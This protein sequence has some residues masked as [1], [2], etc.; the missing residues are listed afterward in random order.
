MCGKFVDDFA[1][2]EPELSQASGQWGSSDAG[3]VGT[4]STATSESGDSEWSELGV[5]DAYVQLA[6]PA[7]PRA[8]Y[9]FRST[10]V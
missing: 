4:A 7:P 8:I 1:C 10:L 3:R 5:A 2:V 9:V 6:L